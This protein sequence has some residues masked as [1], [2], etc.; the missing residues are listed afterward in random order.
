MFDPLISFYHNL[1]GIV[2]WTCDF[3]F[4]VIFVRGILANEIMSELKDRG[5]VR[6]GSLHRLIN[7]IIELLPKNERRTAIFD[8]Y[9]E[10]HREKTVID[11][12]QGHCAI[13]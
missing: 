12:K 8:H 5:V 7:H 2:R 6:K 13:I 4:S 11:C 10:D 3:M 9:R 1:P